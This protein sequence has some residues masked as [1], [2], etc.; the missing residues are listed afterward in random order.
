MGSKKRMETAGNDQGTTPPQ[1]G[2]PGGGAPVLVDDAMTEAMPPTR[3][4]TAPP[5]PN[6]T[7]E[8][9]RKCRLTK[10]QCRMVQASE[11]KQ[12]QLQRQRTAQQ[13]QVQRQLFADSATLSE[14]DLHF[15]IIVN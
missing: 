9:G 14:E 12:R 8:P 6:I 10:G 11:G 3:V 13:W 2:D 15:L 1:G 4:A 7:T 5:T